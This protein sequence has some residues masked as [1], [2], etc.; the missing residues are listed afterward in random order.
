MD[1]GSII[2]IN[3]RKMK[4]SNLKKHANTKFKS[5]FIAFSSLCVWRLDPSHRKTF[6][7]K[8][9]QFGWAETEQNC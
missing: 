5:L 3:V 9:Y 2:F 8:E 7:Q 6:A 4:D 1:S